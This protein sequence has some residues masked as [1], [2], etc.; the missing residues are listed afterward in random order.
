MKLKNIPRQVILLGLVSLFTDMASEMLYPV[1]PIFLSGILGASMAMIGL[2]EGLAELT[3]GVLKGYFGFLSDKLGKRSIF[4]IAGYS[5]SAL[6]KPLPGLLPQ[7]VIVFLSRIA[8]R[9]GKGIRTAPRDALLASYSDKNNKGAI[10]GFH[11]GMDTL[12]AVIGPLFGLLLLSIY[13]YNFRKVYLFALIPSLLAVAVTL[14]IKDKKPE[15]SE[16]NEER[17][18]E[19][20]VITKKGTARY[21]FW[22]ESPKDYRILTIIFTLFSL[23]N[24]SDVFLILRSKDISHSTTTAILVYVFYNLIYAISSYPAGLFSDKYG[25]RNAFIIG[26]VIFSAV[27]FGFGLTSGTA[28]IWILFL[29]YGIYAAFSEGVV[30]AWASDLVPD[31]K[32]ASAIGLLTMLSGFAILIGSLV[33]GILW[34]KF[35]PAVPFIISGI[36][37]LIA[38]LVLYI[39]NK[40]EFKNLAIN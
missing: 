25:K 17:K 7:T 18:A 12:G 13:S 1:T 5:L 23:V 28:I 24:S 14:L 4:V 20:N 3:A 31:N 35:G 26:L 15:N 33:T 39:L 22:K 21:S 34:D 32:R 27:Y 6:S 38:A 11:R 16:N 40:H 10:F 29:F 8:D 30:K 19:N 2:I 36:I 37:S 9:T